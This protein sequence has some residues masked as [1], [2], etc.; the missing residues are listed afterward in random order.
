VTVSIV[1]RDD[2]TRCFG[3]AT[4]SLGLAV[5]SR[6]PVLPATG[7]AAAVQA[8]SPSGWQATIGRCLSEGWPAA[9]IHRELETSEG[10]QAA[11]VAI[12]DAA[13]GVAVLSGPRVEP[14][15]GDAQAS[16]VVAVANLM[17]RPG[18]PEAALA[19]YLESAEST[20]GGRLLDALAAADLLGGDI[21]G[22]QSAA[23][24]VVAPDGSAS[25]P[26]PDL[27]VDDAS[28]PTRE[29]AR[30]HRLWEAHQLLRSSV[31]ADGLYR[32]V[33][34]ALAALDMAPDD[35]TCLGAAA[36][37]LLRDGEVARAVA[38]LRRLIAIEPRTPARLQRLVDV[39]MLDERAGRRALQC[40]QGPGA[41]EPPDGRT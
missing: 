36:L 30:L 38:V 22:R 27:R 5:G 41:A 8:H 14:E 9:R 23:L 32:D 3:V 1:A 26:T 4:A 21:R 34:R 29:L 35:Q 13:G 11:Q 15:A 39:G 17:E 16:G 25:M 37:A 24:R 19:A 6:V 2:E 40:L 7:G 31:G 20:L 28:E 10:A 33:D 12:I 18:V